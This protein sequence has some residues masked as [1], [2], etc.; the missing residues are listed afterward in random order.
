[1]WG[2]GS[3]LRLHTRVLAAVAVAL[4][5]LVLAAGAPAAAL[6]PDGKRA[7]DAALGVPP[8]DES[9]ILVRWVYEPRTLS[10]PLGDLVVGHLKTKVKIVKVK[11]GLTVEQMLLLYRS[12]PG[13]VYAEPN[14]LARGEALA[15]PN[16]Y[17]FP[18]QWALARVKA[19]DAWSVYPGSYGGGGA[20]VAI[21]DT[22]V[23]ASHPDL[24][25]RVAGGAIC[26]TGTCLA[27][28]PVDDNGHGT[29]GAG[30]AAATANN[31]IGVAG[32]SP[33]SPIVP[34]KV[35]DAAGSGTYAAI[36]AGIIWAAD[37]GAR[38]LNLSLTG[39]AFSQTLCD[40]VTYA[41]SK[42]ALV[43][44]AAGNLG[45]SAPVYPAGC[46]GAVGVAATDQDELAPSWSNTGSPNVFVSAPGVAVH[47]TYL[48]GGYALATGTSMSTSFVA[49]LG[50]LLFGQAPGRSVADVRRIIASTADKVGG[51]AY[52]ADPYGTCAGCTWSST[53]GYGRINVQRA[54]SAGAVDLPASSVP[55]PPQPAPDFTI[56]ASP[57]SMT[58]L[59]GG[60]AAYTVSIGALDGFAGAVSLSVTG[61][62]A[63][64]TA[65]FVP[66]SVSTSGS[67]ALTV[68][69][70][71]AT[72]AGSYPLTVRGASGSLAHAAGLTLV[73]AAAPAQAPPSSGFGISVT[74]GSRILKRAKP[75]SFTV[76]VTT[77]PGVSPA[78]VQLS[79][80]GLPDGV[81]ATFLPAS[82][83]APGTSTLKLEAEP[84]V[85]RF[86]T[87]T[88]TITGTSGSVS[89][90]ATV[91]ITVL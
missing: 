91:R 19:L 79:V 80:S 50:G 76:T 57:S 9:T 72:P 74:P 66:A 63:G 48:K 73:V 35:L 6:S 51:A 67:S 28:P 17:F 54:L 26:L 5:P 4:L 61:L 16:D 2:R 32:L 36:A 1:M 49:G 47:T 60:R 15:P 8:R 81:T 88:L 27:G 59:Q 7:P 11:R 69:T 65:A 34:V 87:S 29:L 18:A 20:P 52:G 41:A 31:G 77:S 43:A 44:A 83:L 14:Y 12:L 68:T 55:P 10:T 90:S 46:P 23:D 42:G 33:G 39:P 84:W 25:G 58:T 21:V 75:A 45:S 78:S 38:A 40:A 22:G 13:V 64:A 82:V 3:D 37:S 56:A 85:P 53:H 30:I 24:A 70:A 89:R 71:S 86:S 62:P